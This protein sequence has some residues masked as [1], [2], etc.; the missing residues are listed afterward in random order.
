MKKL[1]I[2]NVLGSGVYIVV[3]MGEFFGLVSAFFGSVF[4]GV[5][6][7]VAALATIPLLLLLSPLISF[8]FFCFWLYDL[9]PLRKRDLSKYSKE[10]QN[11]LF[12]YYRKKEEKRRSEVPV[13][14]VLTILSLAM[15]IVCTLGAIL[16]FQSN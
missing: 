1:C 14:V 10:M 7:M 4:S 3:A 15:T 16:Y 2:F 6:A 12:E 8:I 11:S 13:T 9:F 5:W